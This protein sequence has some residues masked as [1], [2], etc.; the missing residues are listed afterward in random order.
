ML[1]SLKRM[2]CQWW[3]WQFWCS[4]ALA[5]RAALYWAV[6][7]GPNTTVME[8]VSDSLVRHIHACWRSFSVSAPPVPPSTKEQ[9]SVLL[10][11]WLPSMTLFNTP[12]IMAG[13]LVAPPCS[14]DCA[15]RH[16]K[17]SCSHTCGFA[18]PEKLDYLCNLIWQQVP[19]N[20]TS[21][22]MASSRNKTWEELA[23][24]DQEREI[25]NVPVVVSFATD[26]LTLSTIACASWMDRLILLKFKGIGFILWRLSVHLLFLSSAILLL[27]LHQGSRTEGQY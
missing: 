6:S 22:D 4:L 16:S 23:R 7:T 21:S 18:I 12:K 5:N 14:W 26:Q 13:L 17:C 19:P 8:S 24:I 25:V 27:S 15:G 2:V 20:A 10:L 1:L 3:T 11:G 9:I